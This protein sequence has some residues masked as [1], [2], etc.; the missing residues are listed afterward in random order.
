MAIKSLACILSARIGKVSIFTRLE[1]LGL[2]IS[3][4]RV[5]NIDYSEKE[6]SNMITLMIL[7]II[8]IVIL[9]IILAIAS[10]GVAGIIGV[11]LAFSDVIIAG[12]VIYGIV[13]LIQHFRK[14]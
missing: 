13:K 10:V 6:V 9:A 3:R 11:L 14:K 5:K 7:V 8:A 2:G 1:R 12:L 4:G